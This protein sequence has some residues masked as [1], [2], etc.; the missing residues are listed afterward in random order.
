VVCAIILFKTQSETRSFA[1]TLKTAAVMQIVL[2]LVA[3]LYFSFAVLSA[4]KTH[5]VLSSLAMGLTTYP[6]LFLGYELVVSLTPGIGEAMSCGLLNSLGNACGFLVI[7]L[8][9]NFLSE[10]MRTDS[11]IVMTILAV[12]IVVSLVL[13]TLVNTD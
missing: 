2:S 11:V 9:T 3:F 6:M 4:N 12:L 10:G 5:L 1:H 13:M 8:A 7:L